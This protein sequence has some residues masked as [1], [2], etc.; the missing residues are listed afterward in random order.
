MTTRIRKT[1]AKR[2]LLASSRAA[3]AAIVLAIVPLLGALV[4]APTATAAPGVA[5]LTAWSAGLTGPT[6]RLTSTLDRGEAASIAA[7]LSE[8]LTQ[9]PMS[10]SSAAADAGYCNDLRSAGIPG[11]DSA[12]CQAAIKV[13]HDIVDYLRIDTTCGAVITVGAIGMNAGLTSHQMAAVVVLAAKWYGPDL[14]PML[15]FCADNYG[16][17]NSGS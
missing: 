17:G 5:E 11:D 7:A 16:S 4:V 9:E 15:K 6:I 8:Q 1:N 2:S 12:V 13:G 14:L 10:T 3:L